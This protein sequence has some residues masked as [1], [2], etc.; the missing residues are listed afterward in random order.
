MEPLCPVQ[1]CF[2]K[3]HTLFVTLQQQYNNKKEKSANSI[4]N[5][6]IFARLLEWILIEMSAVASIK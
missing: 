6:Q 4:N 5:L 1:V 2:F 3:F